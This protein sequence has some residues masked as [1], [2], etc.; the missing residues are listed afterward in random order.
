MS[1]DSET[2]E[3]L[4]ESKQSVP[5][6][7]GLLILL[8]VAVA[9]LLLGRLDNIYVVV[10]LVAFFLFGALGAVDDW[11]KLRQ[12]GR[13]GMTAIS[14]DAGRSACGWRAPDSERSALP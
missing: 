14:F 2:I 6:M 4:R 9:T 5:T 12:P 13:G 8:S 1:H 10:T 11:T 3:R 7:G